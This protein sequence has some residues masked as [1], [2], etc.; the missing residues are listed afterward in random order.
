VH[1]GQLGGD[2]VEAGNTKPSNWISQT[3]LYPRSANPMAVPMMPD[4]A[5]GVSTTRSGPNSPMSPSVTR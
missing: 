4:S 5:S 3:G 1:L 2:L